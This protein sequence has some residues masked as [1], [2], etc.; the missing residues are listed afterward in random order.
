MRVYYQCTLYEDIDGNAVPTDKAKM[1][2]TKLDDIGI[3]KF[4]III[5]QDPEPPAN[6][7]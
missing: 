7:V 6:E 4:E 3:A 5:P 1:I 2:A